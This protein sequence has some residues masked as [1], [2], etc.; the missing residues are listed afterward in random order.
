MLKLSNSQAD[1]QGIN[2]AVPLKPDEEKEF[3]ELMAF[4]D[5]SS[6]HGAAP[7]PPPLTGE[8]PYEPPTLIHT[9]TAL[10]LLSLFSDDLKRVDRH[11]LLRFV[12][13][14]QTGDGS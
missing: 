8:S 6:E 10:L 3:A 11:S 1:V 9:Y 4:E 2:S 5:S 14:C 13:R 7:V 12:A